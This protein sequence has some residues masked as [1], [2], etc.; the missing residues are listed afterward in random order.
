MTGAHY[1]KNV[2]TIHVRRKFIFSEVEMKT[3]PIAM[4]LAMLAGWINREQE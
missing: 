3:T 1:E 2:F 4:L